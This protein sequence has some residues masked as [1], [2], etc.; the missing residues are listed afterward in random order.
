MK[1]TDFFW[2][3]DGTLFD[4]YPRVNRAIQNALK[5]M[6]IIVPLETIIPLSKTTLGHALETLCPGRKEEAWQRYREHAEEEGYDSM[7]PYKG[8]L[9]LL[10]S[11]CA[12]GGRNYLY[13]HRDKTSLD[14]LAYYGMTPYFT[15]YLTSEEAEARGFRRKPAPDAL[16]YL[17]EKHGLSPDQC[18]M[19]GDRD[20]DLDSG[21]NAGMSCALFDPGHYFDTY[22]TPWRYTT[23]LELT[24]D[25]V[26]EQKPDDLRVSDML[27]LQD[28]QQER[29]PAWGAITPE[30]GPRQ[31][32][33]LIGELGEVID[34]IKKV[35]S[36]HLTVPGE[37]R[38]R[39]VEELADAAMYF[40]DVL[41]CYGVSET[42]FARA[43]YDKVRKNLKRDYAREH[44][45]KYGI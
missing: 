22:D 15:D 28:L 36:D 19:V 34:V 3:F 5:D 30:R 24:A 43:Y 39:L 41:N 9:R 31:L 25:L 1:F 37:A 44:K 8:V 29:H 7:R 16:L 11:I 45:D 26:W 33:W 23:M 20:I 32:L 42:E 6:N 27:A 38:G 10:E 21:K 35:D 4:T 13:T 2:D 14:A 12:S 40:H 18:V 17:M